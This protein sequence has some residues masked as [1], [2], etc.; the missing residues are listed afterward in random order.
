VKRGVAGVV[1]FMGTRALRAFEVSALDYLVKPIEPR[2]LARTVER[3]LDA[4]QADAARP[5][6]ATHRVPGTPS[7]R[8]RRTIACS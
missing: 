5:C 8:C 2:R 3:V 6:R 1:A 4:W 7:R